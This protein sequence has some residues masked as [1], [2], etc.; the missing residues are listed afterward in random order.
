MSTLAH[1]FYVP[2]SFS[3]VVFSLFLSRIK[4]TSLMR[5][6]SQGINRGTRRTIVQ[7]TLSKF[8]SK[9]KKETFKLKPKCEG[10]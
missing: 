2:G 5:Q 8:K 7:S 9:K 6:I 3:F 10:F 4:Y 1:S